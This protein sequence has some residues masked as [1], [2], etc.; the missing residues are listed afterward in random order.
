MI[1][2]AERDPSLA[3]QAAIYTRLTT[4]AEIDSEVY[5]GI[6]EK[7]RGIF[8]FLGEVDLTDWST[9]TDYGK[10][11]VCHLHIIQREEEQGA[12]QVRTFDPVNAVASQVIAALTDQSTPLTLDEEETGFRLRDVSVSDT[13]KSQRL[14]S[15]EFGVARRAIVTV[16]CSVQQI[17]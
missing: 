7:Q 16:I 14:M 13:A 11:V 3:I 12:E 4:G 8:V 1:A 6:P 17:A 2:Y 15:T 5:D 10:Q 9:K